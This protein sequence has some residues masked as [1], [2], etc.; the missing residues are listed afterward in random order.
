MTKFLL[1][2]VITLSSGQ[3]TR[4]E[5]EFDTDAACQKARAKTWKEFEK[6]QLKEL[7]ASGETFAVEVECYLKHLVKPSN[8]T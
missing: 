4:R 7:M 8:P 3:Y 5:A 1:L 6:K 2:I